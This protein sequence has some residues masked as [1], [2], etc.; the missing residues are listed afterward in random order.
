[1][2]F[3]VLASRGERLPNSHVTAMFASIFVSL[4]L[5]LLD[6]SARY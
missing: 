6:S 1:M 3:C 5:R 2:E 4:Q